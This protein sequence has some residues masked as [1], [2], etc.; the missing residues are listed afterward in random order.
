[1]GE[2]LKDQDKSR[3]PSRFAA[4]LRDAIE[5]RGVTLSWLHRRLTDLGSPVSVAA[6]SYWRSGARQPEGEASLRSVDC[7]EHLLALPPG[8]L[9]NRLLVSR[10]TGHVR[11]AEEALYRD[12][13][14]LLHA[15]ARELRVDLA[16]GRMWELSTDLDIVNGLPGRAA[17]STMRSL[18]R[19]VGSPLEEVFYLASNAGADPGMGEILDVLGGSLDRVYEHPEGRAWGFVIRLDEPLQPGET[20]MYGFTRR[21]RISHRSDAHG[22]WHAVGRPCKSITI[23]VEFLGSSHPEWIE[24]FSVTPGE[25]E[26]VVPR[27][28]RG[29]SVHAFRHGFG[30]GRVGL[31]WGYGAN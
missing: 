2:V 7:L 12:E 27:A 21:H 10:R 5:A 31:R 6:L 19:A 11:D 3:P 15:V 17:E 25:E 9:T 18:I 29:A 23:R 4:A 16:R 8:H 1:M 28:L 20:T 13:R 26:T 30:P 22:V 24:E 14:A